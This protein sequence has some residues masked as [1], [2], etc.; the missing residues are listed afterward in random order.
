MPVPPR[1]IRFPFSSLRDAIVI[2]ALAAAAALILHVLVPYNMDEF[3][4]M[5]LIGFWQFP[6]NM[7]EVSRSWYRL[8]IFGTGLHLPMM[9]YDYIGS[10]RSFLYYPLYLLWPSPASARFLGILSLGLQAAVIRKLYRI[11]VLPV[12]AG[13][14]L[15][16]PYFFAHAVDAGPI[17]FG[18]TG[19]FLL[20]LLF[21]RWLETRKQRF[22]VLAS[23]VVF[24]G[25]WEKM[26]FLWLL[27]GIACLFLVE[28]WEAGVF[29][30]G[31]SLRR[32]LAATILPLAVLA[33][34]L[35]VLFLSPASDKPGFYPYW[36]QMMQ[37][38]FRSI[39]SLLKNGFTLDI[40]RA[41]FN[42]LRATVK[43]YAFGNFPLADLPYDALLF[44]WAPACMVWLFLRFPGHRRHLVRSVVY[45][46]AFVLTAFIIIRTKR[47]VFVH[48]AVLSYPFLILSVLSTAAAARAMYGGM[49]TELVTW[50]AAAFLILNLF[51]F[52]VFPTQPM[53]SPTQGRY[54]NTV[55]PTDTIFSV[56][57]DRQLA[58]QAIYAV[59]DWGM[60]FYKFLY[61]AEG[62]SVVSTS[63]SG[64]VNYD[65]LRKLGRLHGREIAVIYSRNRHGKDFL[66]TAASHGYRRCG[67][68]GEDEPWQLLVR[69]DGIFSG[70]CF[71][72]RDPALD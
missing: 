59:V 15:F 44:L 65:V 33:L 25:L 21:R 4:A 67:Q 20:L 62:Q 70:V 36:D 29:S 7:W 13:L 31:A 11:P 40:I 24:L 53:R 52:A 14:C 39:A 19:V 69:S 16:F 1:R 3:I 17:I 58:P 49:W 2:V 35:S 30:S 47:A 66:A 56:T 71:S 60:F 6:A 28:A 27:P 12:F 34:L 38:E 10:P 8:N 55:T 61:G 18:T 5:R 63:I 68:V 46:A 37:A 72:Q 51:Y 26:T 23:L 54:N 50:P 42:P 32:L 9:I 64:V 48:H 45:F 41:F 22:A 43:V 57:D